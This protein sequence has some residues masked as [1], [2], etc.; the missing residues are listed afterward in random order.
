MTISEILEIADTGVE[1]ILGVLLVLHTLFIALVISK[2]PAIIQRLHSDDQRC[3]GIRGFLMGHKFQ[4]AYT[5]ERVYPGGKVPVEEV[6]RLTEHVMRTQREVAQIRLLDRFK[7]TRT[8][9]HG[10]VCGSVW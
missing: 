4:A 8:H 3:T 10:H 2:A 5:D 7:E 1:I 6:E 9:Y